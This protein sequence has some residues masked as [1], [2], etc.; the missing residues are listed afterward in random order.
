LLLWFFALSKVEILQVP[1]YNPIQKAVDLD[2]V[3]RHLDTLRIGRPAEWDVLVFIYGH[4]TSLASAGQ[5]SRLL[6]YNKAIVGAA[7][8]TLT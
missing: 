3:A 6:G 5:I 7:L 1:A 4:G 2:L 8:E